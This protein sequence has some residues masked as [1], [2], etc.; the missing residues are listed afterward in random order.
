MDSSH[1]KEQDLL[2]DHKDLKTSLPVWDNGYLSTFEHLLIG[3]SELAFSEPNYREKLIR[4]ENIP[5]INTIRKVLNHAVTP[6]IAIKVREGKKY[7]PVLV[8]SVSGMRLMDEGLR[9]AIQLPVPGEKGEVD[10]R[11]RVVLIDSHSAE[12]KNYEKLAELSLP[13]GAAEY[14]IIKHEGKEMFLEYKKNEI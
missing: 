7:L 5:G 9:P 13:K 4:G 8:F 2:S 10:P 12:V 14:L 11:M 1:S 6:E 3:S